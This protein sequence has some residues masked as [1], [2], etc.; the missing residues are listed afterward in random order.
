VHVGWGKVGL[1]DV[2]LAMEEGWRGN[3]SMRLKIALDRG[4]LEGEG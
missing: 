4:I 1:R 3:T 2:I